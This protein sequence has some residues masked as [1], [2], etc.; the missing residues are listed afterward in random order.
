MGNKLSLSSQPIGRSTLGTT[1]IG[2][3]NLS[4]TQTGSSVLVKYGNDEK[5]LTAPPAFSLQLQNG[6]SQNQGGGSFYLGLRP[7]VNG[8]F[9]AFN[10]DTAVLADLFGMLP[11]LCTYYVNVCAESPGSSVFIMTLYIVPTV[12]A[13]DPVEL[14]DMLYTREFVLTGD[15]NTGRFEFPYIAYDS[16]KSCFEVATASVS[17]IVNYTPNSLVQAVSTNATTNMT[18]DFLFNGN[19]S[20][21]S[22]YLKTVRPYIA[23]TNL[24]Q[25]QTTL[26][27]NKALNNY[28][29]S[30]MGTL[31]TSFTQNPVPASCISSSIRSPCQI[32]AIDY[33]FK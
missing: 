11:S 33:N 6:V 29:N 16:Y 28:G 4:N 8:N 7:L 15:N 14:L 12:T 21:S 2:Q 27:N 13:E 17:V 1:T 22:N 10:I 20:N 3:F 18:I 23:S 9:R 30:Y 25:D 31:V 19:A 32:G 24:S 5:Y 26:S